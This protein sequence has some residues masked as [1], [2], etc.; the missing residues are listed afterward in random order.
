MAGKTEVVKQLVQAP[1]IDP[2]IPNDFG[3]LPLM[4][5]HVNNH[6]NCAS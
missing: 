2:N 3:R 1:S 5:V 4:E 6:R